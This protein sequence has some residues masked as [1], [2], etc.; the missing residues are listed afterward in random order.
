MEQ[1]IVRATLGIWEL[2]IILLIVVLIF[3]AS[4]LPMLG[5]S[6]GKFIRNLRKG[7]KDG[8]KEIEGQAKRL[9]ELPAPSSESRETDKV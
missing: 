3:G 4:K 9:D 2:L 7:I 8:P 1:Q 6:M 5:E